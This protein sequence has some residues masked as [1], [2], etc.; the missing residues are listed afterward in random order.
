[1]PTEL[2]GRICTRK[3]YCCSLNEGRLLCRPG[4][5]RLG[6]DAGPTRAQSDASRDAPASPETGDSAFKERGCCAMLAGLRSTLRSSTSRCAPNRR[7]RR[8]SRPSASDADGAAAP[9]SR[10]PGRPGDERPLPVRRHRSRRETLADAS[11]PCAR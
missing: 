6:R 4:T 10:S 3:Q 8:P 9:A 2:R 5:G 11:G 7:K 1:M